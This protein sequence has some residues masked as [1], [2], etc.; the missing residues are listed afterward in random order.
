MEPRLRAC[1]VVL[2]N[3]ASEV[4]VQASGGLAGLVL[5]SILPKVCW[6]KTTTRADGKTQQQYSEEEQGTPIPAARKRGTA[7]RGLA[8]GVVHGR[9]KAQPLRLWPWA[10]R[11]GRAA[12]PAG[13]A[14][15]LHLARD[16]G[17][18]RQGRRPASPTEGAREEARY[19]A[20]GPG[21]GRGRRRRRQVAGRLLA[22]RGR[23]S[24]PGAPGRR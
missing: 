10:K 8:A 24:V 17:G 23:A 1:V 18:T 21:L 20:R 5:T 19:G 12:A 16:G 13:L 22:G 6:T 7:R 14:G 15:R 9:R 3:I 2:F 4:V 11:R